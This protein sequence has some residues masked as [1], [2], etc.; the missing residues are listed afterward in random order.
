MSN[1][2]THLSFKA[3]MA[4]VLKVLAANGATQ[5]HT[6]LPRD[7][8][9]KK[10]QSRILTYAELKTL[11]GITYSRQHLKRLEDAGK[12]PRRINP[13]PGRMGWLEDEVDEWLQSK[14]DAR[15]LKKG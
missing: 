10:K 3:P 9:P 2:P 14:A 15:A 8:T 4:A 6:P 11:K 5:T 7:L 12:F 13:S 1:T